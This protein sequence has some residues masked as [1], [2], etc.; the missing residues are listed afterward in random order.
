M[1][2]S[3]KP[4]LIPPYLKEEIYIKLCFINNVRA[5]YLT[6]ALIIYSFFISAYDT[7]LNQHIKHKH[8]FL[9]EFKLDL[10]LVVFSVIFTIYIYFN[11]VKSAKHIKSY[12]KL[13]HIVISF[14]LMCWGAAKACNSSF[15]MELVPQVFL[16]SVIIITIVFYFS[17]YI[18]LL[19]IVV[20]ILFYVIIALYY[21]I[22]IDLIFK[23]GIFNLIII[24]LA[25]LTS[26]LFFHQKMEY[27]LKEYE[28]NRLKDEKLFINGQKEKPE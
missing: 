14:F 12:H 26:R 22:E 11:Q 8:E 25:F 18:L 13:V 20:S 28:I 21:Q 24:F 15:S 2:K 6:I 10:I 7:F 27:F 9:S 17:F 19:Q 23:L 5:K 3:L 4:I 1:P 16:I